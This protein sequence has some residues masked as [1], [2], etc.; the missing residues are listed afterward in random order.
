MPGWQDYVVEPMTQLLTLIADGVGGYGLAILLFTL[1]LRIA[2]FPLT[3]K[4]IRSQKKL[5]D[6]QP[7]IADIKKR[8]RGDRSR[9]SQMTM[10][11][12]KKE[13][14]NPAAGCFPILLQMPIL[15]AMY[16][17]LLTVGGCLGP[18]GENLQVV[19]GGIGADAYNSCKNAG[20]YMLLDQN[21]LWFNLADIDRTI[22]FGSAL[23][24]NW[25]DPATYISVLAILGGLTF[26]IQTYMTVTPSQEPTG[27]QATMQRVMQWYPLFF[28]FIGWVFFSGILLYWVFAAVIQIVQ[29]YFLSGL[30]KFERHMSPETLEFARSMGAG[31]YAPQTSG[32]SAVSAK[33]SQA[34]SESSVEIDDDSQDEVPTR[35]RRRRRRRRRRRG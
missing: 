18:D 24:Q 35:K 15:L 32:T 9:E 2:I 23:P 12:Y 3:M 19:G 22:N 27:A 26:W 20:G 31:K 33:G 5:Q 6:L 8:A 10:E 7:V 25:P 21:F 30:G 34:I 29:Q 4:G 28:V 16:G 11:L 17:A 1:I 14:V 13:G